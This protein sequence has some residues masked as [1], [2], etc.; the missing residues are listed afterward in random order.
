MCVEFNTIM[1]TTSYS[2]ERFNSNC[3]ITRFQAT[4]INKF[5]VICS[6][7]FTYSYRCG[8]LKKQSFIL[9]GFVYY[10]VFMSI[11]KDD[12]IALFTAKDNRPCHQQDVLGA[13][14]IVVTYD[15]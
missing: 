4:A 9:L 8:G 10:S 1:S 2:V 6:T 15:F 13:M 3:Q 12:M 7:P 11:S 5:A 14:C